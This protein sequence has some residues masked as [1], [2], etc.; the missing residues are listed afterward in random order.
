MSIDINW[1]TLTGGTDGAARAE[2]IRAFI[3]DKFQQVTLPRFIR[4]VK[5]HSFDFGSV[6]PEVEIKDI[7]DPLPDFYEED[8]GYPDEHED[9]GQA[10]AGQQSTSAPAP[11]RTAKERRTRDTERGSSSIDEHSSAHQRVPPYVNTRAPGLRTTLTPAEQIGS[12]LLARASTPGIPGGTSNINYFHLPL[13]AGLSGATTPLAA[14]AGAQF[15]GWLDHPNGRPSTPTEM[16]L[17][18]TASFS[19]L[20]LTPQS[21][22][23]PSTRPSSQHQHDASRRNSVA[24]STGSSPKGYD[25]TPSAS[26][27]PRMREKSV[28]DIQVVAHVQYSGDVKMSLTAE[29]LLDYPMP[30]FVGIPLKLNITGLTFDGV[31]ILA[32]IK[33]RAHFCFLSPEDADALVGGETNPDPL[34][35]DSQMAEQQ[36]A[37]RPRIGGLLEHIKVESEIGQK[38]NGKQVLKNVGKVETFV[39][40]QV[41]RIFE[42]EFV[43]PSFWTFLV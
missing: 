43:Y 19:S 10:L 3:H 12:P 26:P 2:T 20:T 32:Y 6:P 8:E 16:R 29:I 33:K 14:V 24:E 30:S 28:E 22:P 18:N 34:Q 39:L 9:D 31:A 27:P 11:P 38:E 5:V 41:R 15:P 35:T 40:E 17:R 21:N 1:D 4:A 42:D 25:R 36:G 13:G 37:R 23:D 7:C